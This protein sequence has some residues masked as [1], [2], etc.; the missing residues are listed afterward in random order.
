MLTD[1]LER[2]ELRPDIIY[3]DGQGVA[4]PRRFGLACH[5]GLLTSTPTIGCAKSI[6]VGR[7]GELQQQ[8]GSQASMMHKDE[9]VGAALRTRAGIKPMYIS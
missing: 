3:I 1:A 8:A 4:H 2:L 7:H 9:E 5:I 6:L